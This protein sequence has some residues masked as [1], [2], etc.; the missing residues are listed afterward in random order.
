MATKKDF[1]ERPKVESYSATL[2]VR[3]RPSEKELVVA[4]AQKNDVTIDTVLRSALVAF[5]AL[6]NKK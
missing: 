1:V 3:V 4:F 2:A 6:P 5:G